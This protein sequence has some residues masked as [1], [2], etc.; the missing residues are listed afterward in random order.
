MRP[1]PCIERARTTIFA[2]EAYQL[3]P[4]YLSQQ[5]AAA[6]P[7]AQLRVLPGGHAGFVQH[8]Q[9]YNKAFIEALR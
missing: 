8:S 4:T 1:N 3:T 7:Q 5:L 9:E 2:G 6:I